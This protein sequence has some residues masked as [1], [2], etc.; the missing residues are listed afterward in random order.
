MQLA[1]GVM[2]CCLA[3]DDWATLRRHYVLTN[4]PRKTGSGLFRQINLNLMQI[5]RLTALRLESRQS[6][7]KMKRFSIRIGSG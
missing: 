5:F 3:V 2:G 6:E 1:S 4:A 7:E